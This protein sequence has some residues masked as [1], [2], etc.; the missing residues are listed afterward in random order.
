MEHPMNSMKIT[1][2]VVTYNRLTLLQRTINALRLQTHKLS[3]IIVV[4]N[5][6]TDGTHEWLDAQTDLT[7]I[8]QENVGGS[9][10][11]WRGIKEGYER[12]FDWLWCMDDDVYPELD[13][14]EHLL[15]TA[16]P[17][18]GMLCPLR[19]QNGK[20]FLSEVRSFN[21]RNPFRSLHAHS[22]TL[23]DIE[24]EATVSIEGIAFEGP[25]IRREVVEKIGLP[26]KDLFLLYDDSDYSLRAVLAGYRVRLVT[27]GILNKELF[28]ANDD[29]AT[30]R[31]KGKWKLYYH[32]RNTVWFNRT[33][34]RN[35]L[36]CTLRPVAVLLQYEL[37]VLKNLPFNKKYTIRDARD[38]LTA[39]RHGCNNTLGKWNRNV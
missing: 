30:A 7:V 18:D 5:G 6:A 19:K 36:V 14:L 20:I 22:L 2:V 25:L 21:L 13:C 3:S 34:G 33:Y 8:H 17:E 1:A 37:Y 11:F 4:D 15:S 9:G 32:I 26:N 27:D 24:G 10:G 38:F 12:G 29:I 16:E 39:Y 31:Q 28:F 23:Q 35:W